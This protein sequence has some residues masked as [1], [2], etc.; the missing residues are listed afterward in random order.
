MALRLD[1]WFESI[2]DVRLS[3]LQFLSGPDIVAV[4]RLGSKFRASMSTTPDD[5]W[6]AIFRH[7]F[8][9]LPWTG[10][11]I[12]WRERLFFEYGLQ[13]VPGRRAIGIA[14]GTPRTGLCTTGAPEVIDPDAYRRLHLNDG[15]DRD[16]QVLKGY[17]SQLVRKLHVEHRTS[18]MGDGLTCAH[19]LSVRMVFNDDFN[20][21]DVYAPG[22]LE[23]AHVD[24]E[25]FGRRVVEGIA[26]YRGNLGHLAG[27]Y[28]VRVGSPLRALL[29]GLQASVDE[30]IVLEDS[31][32]FYPSFRI[33]KLAKVSFVIDVVEGD[34]KWETRDGYCG[35][36]EDF[37][38]WWEDRL[39]CVIYM[40]KVC[41]NDSAGRH[42]RRGQ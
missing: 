29:Q 21:A 13:I 16:D 5:V 25:I 34:E 3:L 1:Q 41:I 33:P 36:D 31:D 22:D 6:G 17:V 11:R 19:A 15:T 8:G 35:G 40:I 7:R 10:A 26:I 37:A 12:C 32:H 2:L 23:E 4:D 24:V 20:P 18:F 27:L 38:D 9:S 30:I 42:V 39:G 28:G 14:L